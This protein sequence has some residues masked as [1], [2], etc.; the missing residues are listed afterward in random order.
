MVKI[1]IL[2][3]LA[4]ACAQEKFPSKIYKLIGAFVLS[5][6]VTCV[7]LSILITLPNFRNLRS[8]NCTDSS[9]HVARAILQWKGEPPVELSKY[10]E[11]EATA[12][13]I[14]CEGE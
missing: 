10:N 14:Y 2:D 7:Q 6:K 4:N 11:I 9:D 3:T 8:L 12:I 5:T 13:I 1:I